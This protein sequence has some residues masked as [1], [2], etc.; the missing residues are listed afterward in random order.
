VSINRA[1]RDVHVGVAEDTIT[2]MMPVRT[3]GMQRLLGVVPKAITTQAEISFSDVGEASARLLNIDVQ[4]VNWFSTYRVHHRVADHFQKGRCFIAGDAGHIH[5]PVGGQGMN[6]GLGD[7]MNLSWKLAQVSANR[8]DAR[9]LDTY[10]PER[11]AFAQQLIATTDSLFQAMVAEGWFARRLRTGI[12]PSL[13]GLFTQFRVTKRTLFKSVSQIRIAYPNSALS[14]GKQ[15]RIS[16]GDRLPFVPELDNHQSL[17]HLD[18]QVH[19]YG[20]VSESLAEQAE[21][22]GLTITSFPCSPAVRAA[23]FAPNGAYLIRPDGYIAWV[24]PNQETV[25]LVD[26][27]QTWRLKFVPQAS[28]PN[29]IAA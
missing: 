12:A 22:L 11:I 17:N 26:Y 20:E 14:L 2:L 13:I 9:L 23:G 10:E 8:A 24:I 1:N 7:A 16:P 19:I 25:S 5:S 27:V 18:W 6:T 29:A 3:S 21:S 15:G 28:T 4:A